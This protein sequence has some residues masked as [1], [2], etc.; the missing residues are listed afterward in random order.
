MPDLPHPGTSSSGLRKGQVQCDLVADLDVGERVR[1]EM[2]T[3][4][5][6]TRVNVHDACGAVD[7]ADRCRHVVHTHHVVHVH[8][9]HVLHAPIRGIGGS[10]RKRQRQCECDVS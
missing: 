3:K 8:A 1:W 10:S 4:F 5:H 9:L 6:S 7:G 2:N